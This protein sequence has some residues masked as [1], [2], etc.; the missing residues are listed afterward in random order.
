MS[1]KTMRRRPRI[2]M[3][4]KLAWLVLI[5][6]NW[7]CIFLGASALASFFNGLSWWAWYEG[8]GRPW[9]ERP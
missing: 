2:S 6:F 9:N 4:P 5:L 3:E 1:D 7:G 8:W